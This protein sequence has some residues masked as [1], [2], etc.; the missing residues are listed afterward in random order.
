MAKY[1]DIYKLS[2]EANNENMSPLQAQLANQYA[3][4]DRTY[5]ETVGMAEQ[6]RQNAVYD[7][8]NAYKTN[9]SNYGR[10]AETALGNGLRGSGYSSYADAAAFNAQ[11][12]EVAVAN[13]KYADAVR[14]AQYTAD[15]QKYA[16]NDAYEKGLQGSYDNLANLAMQGALSKDEILKMAG[17]AGI[18]NAGQLDTLGTLAG[19]SYDAITRIPM[20]EEAYSAGQSGN[21][22]YYR[23]ATDPEAKKRMIDGIVDTIQNGGDANYNLAQV[24]TVL[25]DGAEYK[26]VIDAIT[27]AQ[28]P[29]VVG[30]FN[31]QKW[32]TAS[33][34]LV[35][36]LSSAN[37][38]YAVKD[39]LVDQYI[40]LFGNNKSAVAD[41]KNQFDALE[42]AGVDVTDFRRKLDKDTETRHE[43][44]VAE[45]KN[46]NDNGGWNA[47]NDINAVKNPTAKSGY[48]ELVEIGMKNDLDKMTEDE[49]EKAIAAFK[50]MFGK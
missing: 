15:Q 23:T 22:D 13:S 33:A 34:D 6:A 16:A 27:A 30:R 31:G 4:A 28:L 11:R 49:K 10:S 9:L 24:K 1:E 2:Q 46:V 50:R 26:R 45:N 40:A 7:A 36:I 20:L 38:T 19:K 25:G 43:S 5:A 48:Q 21:L 3:S 37:T 39:N 14:Q 41:L 8:Q 47:V 29:Q 12:G 17:N 32:Q 44:A 35:S 18:T 42:K